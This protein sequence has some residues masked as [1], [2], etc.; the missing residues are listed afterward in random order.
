M[1]VYK[2][3][4]VATDFAEDANIAAEKVK[5]IAA[6]LSAELHIIH[7][8]ASMPEYS[9]GYM[10]VPSIEQRMQEE[11]QEALQK[12][13]EFLAVPAERQYIAV[14]S[15]KNLVLAK[16]EELDVDAIVVGS[17]GHHGWALLLGSTAGAIMHNAN[18]DI[19]VIKSDKKLNK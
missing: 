8:V 19:I 1:S 16:A 14:G 15:P 18:C 3:I 9:I 17:H 7:V 11:A 13:G 4:L 5:S 12:M 6:S 10:M 2:K